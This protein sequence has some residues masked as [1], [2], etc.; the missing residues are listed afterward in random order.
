MEAVVNMCA[1]RVSLCRSYIG[2]L[3]QTRALIIPS[4]QNRPAIISCNVR[5]SVCHSSTAVFCRSVLLRGYPS[6]ASRLKLSCVDVLR[7]QTSASYSSQQKSTPG[8][9]TGDILK[10]KIP[11]FTASS[12]VPPAGDSTSAKK[13]SSDKS[14]SSWF[15]SKNAWKLG[16]V[17]LAGM[18]ILMFGNV[19]LLWGMINQINNN[20]GAVLLISLA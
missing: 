2:L 5:G 6:R 8:S 17:S 7:A 19:L 14:D 10:A 18:G 16:L 4:T 11:T 13:S 9:L 3:R 12:E 1:V 15:S 20:F